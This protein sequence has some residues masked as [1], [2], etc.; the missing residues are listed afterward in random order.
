VSPLN[1]T[2]WYERGRSFASIA[3]FVPNVGG[4]V[5]NGRDGT[6]ETVT[7]QW[8]T[9]GFFDVLGVKPVAGRTFLPSDHAARANVVVISEGLCQTRF[10]RDPAV[11][12]REVRLDG[13]MF[14]IVGV[15]PQEAQLLGR[16][17]LWAMVAFDRRPALRRAYMLRAIGRM[18]P[19]VAVDAAR[20]EL[21][22]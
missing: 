2:D 19:G 15:V 11:V 4:M 10:E 9:A 21:T 18:K 8:V 20:A 22:G 16:T 7:R 14:T 13:M 3:G 17:N 6:A 1:M 12:G 5:M